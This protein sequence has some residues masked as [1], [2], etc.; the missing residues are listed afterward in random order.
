MLSYEAEKAIGK[1]CVELWSLESD[2][3]GLCWAMKL[4]KRLEGI[5]LSYEA[6]KVIG[7][8]CVEL[9]SWESDWKGLCWA[10]KLRKWL[11]GI[12][13]SYEAEKVVGRDCVELWS[14]ESDWKGLCWVMKLRKWLEGIVLSYEAEKV[15][16]RDCVELWSWG[17]KLNSLHCFTYEF[18][19]EIWRATLR[20]NFSVNISETRT[21]SKWYRIIYIWSLMSLSLTFAS[22]W[23]IIRFK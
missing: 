19:V 22:P 5:V 18:C 12:V 4:R 17:R 23:I 20:R 7:R 11:E 13:L 10:M 2:W 3:K 15:I 21:W 8:D 14:W 16:G 1:D 9:W 6:E